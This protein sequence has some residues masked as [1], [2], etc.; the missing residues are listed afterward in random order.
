MLSRTRDGCLLSSTKADIT[1]S[2]HFLGRE[3]EKADVPS[4]DL[5]LFT[6]LKHLRSS[7]SE[8]CANDDLGTH[9]RRR[10]FLVVDSS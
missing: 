4:E 9:Q 8:T 5:C 2:S 6:H 7:I 10:C 1:Q 3:N